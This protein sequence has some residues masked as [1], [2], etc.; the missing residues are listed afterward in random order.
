MFIARRAARACLARSYQKDYIVMPRTEGHWADPEDVTKRIINIIKAH[1]AIKDPSK[2][3][4]EVS[5]SEMGLSDLDIVEV[6][7]EVEKDFFMELSDDQV[8][9]FKTINDAVEV[10]SNYRFADNY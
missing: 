1:D 2:V 8:E 4:P 10:I 6:F 7:F 3:Q 9:S 5:L